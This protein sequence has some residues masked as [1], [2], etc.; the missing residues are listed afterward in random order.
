MTIR[1]FFVVCFTHG[2]SLMILNDSAAIFCLSSFP[3]IYNYERHEHYIYIWWFMLQPG[4]W[5]WGS[6]AVDWCFLTVYVW[7]YSSVILYCNIYH[8]TLSTHWGY[9][10]SVKLCIHSYTFHGFTWTIYTE[11]HQTNLRVLRSDTFV[12]FLGPW[13]NAILVNL[14]TYLGV[15]CLFS[16]TIKIRI[17]L[18]MLI[19]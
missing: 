14:S 13:K 7:A 6:L 1:P 3:W 10:V 4:H 9:P 2:W 11:S 12:Y 17:A 5:P 15:L 19:Y 8:Q 18:L 16:Y